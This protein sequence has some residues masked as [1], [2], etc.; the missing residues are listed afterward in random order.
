VSA[1]AAFSPTDIAG[2]K[3]WLDFSDASTLFT[4]A[5]STPVSSDGDAI[6]QAND[7]SGRGNHAV[8]ANIDCR[9]F[10]KTA[11]L[12]SLSVGDFDGS[13]DVLIVPG[14]DFDN[15]EI[16]GHTILFVA[17]TATSVGI[18]LIRGAYRPGVRTHL[19]KVSYANK[20]SNSAV[21]GVT[22]L[23]S[24]TFY[25]LGYMAENPNPTDGLVEIILNGGVDNSGTVN[26]GEFDLLTYDLYIGATLNSQA[27]SDIEI[28]ELWVYSHNL[29]DIE[30][31]DLRNY[32][33]N[34]WAIY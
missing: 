25:F 33:N 10:Y 30:L 7:K 6:Y 31:T 22:A 2:L 34:K 3:L 18:I 24:D 21:V 12:N 13:N 26:I 16:G 15:L 9:P 14:G 29:T 32:A 11:V 4:D 19:S 23:S 28:G 8:Q 1:G 17:R 5:G 27:P 20:T